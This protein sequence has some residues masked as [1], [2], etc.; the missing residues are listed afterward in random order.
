MANSIQVNKD[1]TLS[2]IPEIHRDVFRPADYIIDKAYPVS[3]FSKTL[4]EFVTIPSIISGL[5]VTK[6]VGDTLNISAGRAIL[7]D[8]TTPTIQTNNQDGSV[9]GTP[10][11]IEPLQII[12]E[13]AGATNLPLPGGVSAGQNKVLIRYKSESFLTRTKRA[14]ILTTYPFLKKD[15]CEI[16]VVPAA[17]IVPNTLEIGRF[18][19]DSAINSFLGDQYLQR[20]AKLNLKNFPKFIWTLGIDEV[21]DLGNE[22]GKYI[23]VEQDSGWEFTFKYQV[24]LPTILNIEPDA[25]ISVTMNKI[26]FINMYR[27][28]SIKIQNKTGVARTII[29]YQYKLS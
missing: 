2:G 27:D 18:T 22:I 16:L 5:V 8:A 12:I 15:G 4:S 13:Y 6:G 17:T 21:I 1:V 3:Q 29:V 26:G 20:S 24:A 23:C 19:G 14:D 7:T 11:P 10:I 9:L 28:T 25:K